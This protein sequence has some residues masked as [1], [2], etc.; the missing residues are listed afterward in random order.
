MN[1]PVPFIWEAHIGYYLPQ[2][3]VSHQWPVPVE[4]LRIDHY[5]VFLVGQSHTFASRLLLKL[6][7]KVKKKKL[8]RICLKYKITKW[9]QC[10][11]F[12]YDKKI[13]TVW[14][15]STRLLVA[16]CCCYC[17]LLAKICPFEWEQP[18]PAV[19]YFLRLKVDWIRKSFHKLKKQPSE[20]S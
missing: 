9:Q 19:P 5:F 20:G 17:C 8:P 1:I 3:A 2:N 11:A 4:S 7:K 16:G 13:V 10:D 18:I 12:C 14:T 6:A 15:M